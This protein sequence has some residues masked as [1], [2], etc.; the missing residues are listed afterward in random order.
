MHFKLEIATYV[1]SVHIDIGNVLILTALCTGPAT[2][3]PVPSRSVFTIEAKV[4]TFSVKFC[5]CLRIFC[6]KKILLWL[7]VQFDILRLKVVL[8][9]LGRKRT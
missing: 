9:V 3:S 6:N 7:H 4:V 8:F 2:S 5:I 1:R